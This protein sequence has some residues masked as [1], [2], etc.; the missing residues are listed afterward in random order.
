MIDKINEIL[1]GIDKDQCSSDD[2][3][4][5]TSSGAEFGAKKLKEVQELVKKLT[6]TDV[7]CSLFDKEFIKIVKTRLEDYEIAND[8]KLQKKTS[9]DI[10]KGAVKW[11]Y[12]IDV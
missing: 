4:W 8:H 6:L 10:F 9:V 11:H 12:K 5:E 7:G 2:G 1:K 3:W